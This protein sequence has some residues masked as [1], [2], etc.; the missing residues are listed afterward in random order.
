MCIGREGLCVYWAMPGAF[1]LD[2]PRSKPIGPSVSQIAIGSRP[3]AN[4]L[5]T[6]NKRTNQTIRERNS[7][8]L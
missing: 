4:R 2:L 1:Q 6:N 7:V 5:A 3:P 8:P